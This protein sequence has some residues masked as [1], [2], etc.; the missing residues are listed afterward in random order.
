MSFVSGVPSSSGIW[1]GV[2]GLREIPTPLNAT[3]SSPG[4]VTF[5]LTFLLVDYYDDDVLLS[6]TI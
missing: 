6:C 3:L 5:Y 4:N 1:H 2:N